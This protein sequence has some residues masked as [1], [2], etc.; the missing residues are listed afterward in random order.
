MNSDTL[1]IQYIL[2]AVDNDNNESIMKYTMEQISAMKNDVLQ[3]LQL[4]REE[5]KVIHKKLKAYRYVNDLTDLRYGN[6]IRWVTLKDPNNI[7]L[8]NG[9]LICDTKFM[10]TGVHI[11]C[12]NKM[13]RMFQIKFDE[14]LIFQKLSDQEQIILDVIKYLKD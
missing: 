2:N 12:K 8:T 7:R 9:G 3:Q 4:P 11:L 13:N 5:L 6:Y 14:N 10:Q 1:D